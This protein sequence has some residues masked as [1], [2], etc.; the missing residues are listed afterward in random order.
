MVKHLPTMWETWV[1]SLGWEDPLE[2]EMATHSSSLAWK[3]PWTKDPGRLQFWGSQRVGHD[4]ATSLS[5]SLCDIMDCST[6]GFPVLHY[7]PEFAQTHVHWVSDAIQPPHPLLPPS[8]AALNLSQH[9]GL[10]QWVSSLHQ[11]AKVLELQ[12]QH[13]CFQWIFRVDF[14]I[15]WFDRW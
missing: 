5:L 1:W 7:L 13:Q 10:F 11:M 2:K 3:I 9:Q 12:L 15:D 4:W 6:L 14:R 8:L